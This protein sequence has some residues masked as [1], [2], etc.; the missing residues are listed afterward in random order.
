MG[1]L[2]GINKSNPETIKFRG[3][4]EK[5]LQSQGVNNVFQLIYPTNF[6]P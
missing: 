6:I 2:P 3:V 5:Q 1:C 4:N